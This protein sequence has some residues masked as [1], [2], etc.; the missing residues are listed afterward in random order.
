MSNTQQ[1]RPV[2]PE[3]ARLDPWR[4]RPLPA[5]AGPAGPAAP[6]Q[7]WIALPGSMTRALGAQ[8]GETPLVTPGYEGPG[9]LARWESRLLGAATRH[10]YVREV[11]LSVRGHAVLSARTLSLPNDPAVNVLRRLSSRP[12]AEVLFQDRRWQRLTPPV[13]VIEGARRRIGRACVW[14]HRCHGRRWD[15]SGSRILVTEYF[16]PVLAEG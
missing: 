14:G 11:T 15:R 2:R 9:R 3:P 4:V 8:F 10:A 12:L 1:P 13:P 7:R 5:P 16:E 6:Y